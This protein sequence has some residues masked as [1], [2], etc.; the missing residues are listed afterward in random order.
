MNRCLNCENEYEPK[1]AASKFC[2]DNCRVKYHRKHGKKNSVS[3]FQ[4][5]VL[6]NSLLGL[7]ERIE[8]GL[9]S[10]QQEFKERQLSNSLNGLSNLGSVPKIKIRRTFENFV[11]LKREC[12]CEEDW[13]KLRQE[14]ENADNLS[15]KQ[16]H[17]L[18]TQTI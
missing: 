2:S 3:K 18:L 17:L 11:T 7:A 5:D 15:Q 16:I 4:L 13:L 1:R 12:E 10:V 6:Y 9:P 8:K 14:I